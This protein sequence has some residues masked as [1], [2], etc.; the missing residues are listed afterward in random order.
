MSSENFEQYLKIFQTTLKT[1]WNRANVKSIIPEL[2][3]RIKDWLTISKNEASDQQHTVIVI[4]NITRCLKSLA[5]AS[6][7]MPDFDDE[8]L[9]MDAV[10]WIEE[11]VLIAQNQSSN[12][13]LSS[14]LIGSKIP[15]SIDARSPKP[16]SKTESSDSTVIQSSRAIASSPL[17]PSI[18]SLVFGTDTK[19]ASE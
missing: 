9:R 14:P 2:V 13:V 16:E 11:L 18:P 19:K 12:L 6:R 3:G 5:T 4:G 15:L 7:N 10:K 8:P 17:V 1:S